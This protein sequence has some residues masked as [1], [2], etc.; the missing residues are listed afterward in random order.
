MLMTAYC[1]FLIL[2]ECLILQFNPVASHCESINVEKGNAHI[3]S[4]FSLSYH[5]SVR[6]KR[7]NKVHEIGFSQFYLMFDRESVERLQY[8]NIK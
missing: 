2:H 8:I 4:F 6:K 1:I 3:S 7:D 5:L